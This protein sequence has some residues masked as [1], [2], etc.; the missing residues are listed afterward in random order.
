MT[1]TKPSG[2]AERLATAGTNFSK[3]GALNKVDPSIHFE[4]LKS[5]SDS[6]IRLQCGVQPE[7]AVSLWRLVQLPNVDGE[8][9]HV[10]QHILH[11]TLRQFLHQV[12][13]QRKREIEESVDYL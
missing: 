12:L 8:A 4:P 6:T 1:L 11:H 13:Q 10:V 5:V 2:V 9:L 3:P 7:R